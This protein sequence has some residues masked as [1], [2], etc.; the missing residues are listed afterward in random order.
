M[1]TAANLDVHLNHSGGWIPGPSEHYLEVESR[2]NQAP[3]KDA[4]EVGLTVSGRAGNSAGGFLA[5]AAGF[6]ACCSYP[7]RFTQ[8][9]IR[10]HLLCVAQD[11]T[12]EFHP[13][14][15]FLP[16]FM[17]GLLKAYMRLNIGKAA[18]HGCA[19]VGPHCPSWNLSLPPAIRHTRILSCFK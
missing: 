13:Y 14:S 2:R 8:L 9:Y 15:S 10:R 3:W 6:L 4:L 18:C 17:L 12:S 19:F 7:R 11:K 16:C 5:K 1:Q